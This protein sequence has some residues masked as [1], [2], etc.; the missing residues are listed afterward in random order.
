[1]VIKAL[2]DMKPTKRPRQVGV[3]RPYRQG[4]RSP[5]LG[6]LVP[7]KVKFY[8][9]TTYH[10]I[11]GQALIFGDTSTLGLYQ[12]FFLF[13]FFGSFFQKLKISEKIAKL[14]EFSFSNFSQFFP[15]FVGEKHRCVYSCQ[16]KEVTT[17]LLTPWLHHKYGKRSYH[18]VAHA[19]VAN[20][21]NPP[22]GSSFQRRSQP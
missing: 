5:K 21:N 9:A 2:L 10:L 20:P 19:L 11:L 1:M 7:T 18:P 16:T 8:L 14:I 22:F 13:L 12:A 17:Y 3:K 4:I 6:L 15:I